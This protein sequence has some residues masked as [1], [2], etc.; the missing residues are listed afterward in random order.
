MGG[1]G[2]S[3]KKKYLKKT[4]KK[5]TETIFQ[6]CGLSV[7]YPLKPDVLNLRGVDN[8]AIY[9]RPNPVLRTQ[10]VRTSDPTGSTVRPLI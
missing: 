9:V 10:S 1:G 3:L 8:G 5:T 7:R 2:L 4:Q 6:K